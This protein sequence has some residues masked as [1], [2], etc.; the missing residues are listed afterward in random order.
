MSSRTAQYR[1][2]RTACGGPCRDSLCE[3]F[4]YHRTMLVPQEKRYSSNGIYVQII[5]LPLTPNPPFMCKFNS[6]LSHMKKHVVSSP[7]IILL[8]AHHKWNLRHQSFS[9]VA[10]PQILSQILF[11]LTWPERMLLV[12]HKHGF[13]MFFSCIK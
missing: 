4:F 5:H 3:T 10:L 1:G 7:S 9:S 13:I 8:L 11:F 12:M 2:F 6:E